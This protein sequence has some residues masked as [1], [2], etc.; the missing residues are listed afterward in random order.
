[1]HI[2][3]HLQK[4]RHG[5]WYYRWVVPAAVR[6]RHPG[7]PRE[8]KR[9]THTAD[10]RE[11]RVAARRL[12]Q[13]FLTKLVD[14][15]NMT[16]PPLG[17]RYQGF[18]VKF[19]PQTGMVTEVDAKPEEAAVAAKF[20]MGVNAPL[21]SIA[22]AKPLAAGS[23]PPART[24]S[25]SESEAAPVF[26]SRAFAKYAALHRRGTWT[27]NTL[28][29]HEPTIRLFRE[30]VGEDGASTQAT[31]REAMDLPLQALTPDKLVKF[32]EEFWEYPTRQGTRG[33]GNSAR[34]ILKKGGK[35]QSRDNVFKQLGKVRQFLNFCVEKRW[36]GEQLIRE[37]DLVLKT[38]TDKARE[39]AR[40]AGLVDGGSADGGY[41]PFSDEELTSLFGSA[42]G[43]H[44]KDNAARYW[45]P[46]IALHTGMRLAEIS[47]LQP[48]DFIEVDR[49]MC[50]QVQPHKCALAKSEQTRLKTAASYRAV[51]VH[52]ALIQ[53]G[54]LNHVAHQK[55]SGK[56]WM[57][58]GLIWS[59]ANQ[60]GKYPGDDF[61]RLSVKTNV[62]MPR[63]KVFHSFRS[64]LSQEL[65]AVGMD[66]GL[67]DR[68]IGHEVGSTRM[69]SYS[70]KDKGKG[71]AFPMAHAFALLSKV[72]FPLDFVALKLIAVTIPRR[73]SRESKRS[74][75]GVWAA[76][77]RPAC[78]G[79]DFDGTAT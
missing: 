67:V 60:F 9:S 21:L 24:L 49:V 12:H 50:I 43:L 7:L 8:L 6:S 15:L 31:D 75:L 19:D 47:Q 16:S 20:V 28:K 63:R 79:C 51:P 74:P 71:K 72:K 46:L 54:L 76:D 37:I 4:S 30:L 23:T 48:G 17:A 5:I 73:T 13:A 2:P 69:K 39:N 1:M 36:V 42:F 11:A 58:E 29:S 53:L 57:W 25:A 41:L 64:T 52:P 77:E 62:Y 27:E 44:S 70:R 22:S 66:P 65:E 45:I 40:L 32:L 34:E 14:V 61:K 56:E 59:E 3:D 10:I 18:T 26:L 78:V 33:T 55:A 38:D 35:P 68:F